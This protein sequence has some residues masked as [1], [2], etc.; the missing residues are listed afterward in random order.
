VDI[1]PGLAT[2]CVWPSAT[3]H[4]ARGRVQRSC[5]HWLPPPR[6]APSEGRGDDLPCPKP[7]EARHSATRHRSGNRGDVEQADSGGQVEWDRAPKPKR[8][9]PSRKASAPSA[10]LVSRR[11]RCTTKCRRGQSKGALC[12][13]GSGRDSPG[14]RVPPR[15]V[16]G[17]GWISVYTRT[18]WTGSPSGFRAA[19]RVTVLNVD[20]G[21]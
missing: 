20:P 14:Y 8:R 18:P 21:V 3:A 6:R 2:S 17:I 15:R 12:W 16:T 1:T 7:V 13:R 11:R 10:R 4:C 9:A 5:H 19:A